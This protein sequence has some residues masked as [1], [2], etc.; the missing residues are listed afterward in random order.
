[1]NNILLRYGNKGQ[2]NSPLVW[3]VFIDGIEHRASEFS[4]KG[5]INDVITYE[6]NGGKNYNV[7]CKGTVRWE[8]TKIFI[9]GG[10]I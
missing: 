8:G 1:M 9:N 5:E 6:E 7:S 2:D 10:N 4:I 3:R